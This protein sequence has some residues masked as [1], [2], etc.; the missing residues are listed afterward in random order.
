MIPPPL[1]LFWLYATITLLLFCF[2][3]FQLVEAEGNILQFLID[4]FLK[5][6]YLF[7][8]HCWKREIEMYQVFQL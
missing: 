1:K 2:E 3:G 5:V 8:I 7:L 6:C 4:T